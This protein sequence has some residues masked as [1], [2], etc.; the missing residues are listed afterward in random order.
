MQSF[1]GVINCSFKLNDTFR[2]D[3]SKSREMAELIEMESGR[4]LDP[5]VIFKLYGKAIIQILEIY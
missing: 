5:L 2:G 3:G 1:Q 4:G